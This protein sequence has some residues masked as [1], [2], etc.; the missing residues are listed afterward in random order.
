MAETVT[1]HLDPSTTK[2]GPGKYKRK[3]SQAL[4]D[5][6]I[7][8]Y[9]LHINGSSIRAIADEIDLKSSRSAWDAV[10]RGRAYVK[11]KG[12]DL[13]LRRID[14]DQLFKETLC[15]L[16]LEVQRQ[17]DEGRITEIVRS[18]G[19]KEIKRVRGVCPR[20]AE[21]LARSADRWGQFLGLTDR[22]DEKNS[23]QFNSVAFGQLMGLP[24]QQQLPEQQAE[25]VVEVEVQQAPD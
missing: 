24:D 16:A 18:D 12:I 2:L 19:T 1:K 6:D 13:E 25:P 14:I 10:N 5:R 8:A 21:A 17:V 4:I 7:R 22:P 20:T 11:E 23:F 9:Q 15:A 3:R